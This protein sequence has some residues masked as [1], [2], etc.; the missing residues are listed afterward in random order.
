MWTEKSIWIRFASNATRSAQ[1]II[2]FSLNH[3]VRCRQSVAWRTRMCEWVRVSENQIVVRIYWRIII[4]LR[5]L[6]RIKMINEWFWG[7]KSDLNRFDSISNTKMD[8]CYERC[9]FVSRNVRIETYCIVFRFIQ[10]VFKCSPSSCGSV[11][12]H[13]LQRS[14]R[15]VRCRATFILYSF[16]FCD[17]TNSVYLQF[18]IFDFS[19]M[20]ECRVATNCECQRRSHRINV[21]YDVIMHTSAKPTRAKIYNRATVLFKL[22]FFPLLLVDCVFIR[23][24]PWNLIRLGVEFNLGKKDKQMSLV[25]GE[26]P[27]QCRIWMM[28]IF[29]FE[30]IYPNRLESIL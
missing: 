14:T 27:I 8:Y 28:N 17:N 22:I 25:G 1:K 29:I 18:T 11:V 3:T 15:W 21:K 24:G 9:E 19:R 10:N 5:F 30:Y 6:S 13:I 26:H 20:Y 4:I 23:S 12:L 7:S 2:K 16:T